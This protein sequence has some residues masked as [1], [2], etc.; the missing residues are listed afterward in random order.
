MDGSLT[1]TFIVYIDLKCSQILSLQS[2]MT[3]MSWANFYI[4]TQ[5]E[6]LLTFLFK[7]WYT[8]RFIC[9]P[10]TYL[11]ISEKW[12]KMDIAQQSI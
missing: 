6:S 11:Y 12:A 10:N 4:K 5:K 3:I 1:L 2:S 8:S 9:A 7:V